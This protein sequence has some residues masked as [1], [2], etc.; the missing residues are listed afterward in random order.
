MQSSDDM[1]LVREYADTGSEAA[2]EAL[3]NR[4]LG[5][6]YSAA[7]RQ[8][9][10]RHLAED[11]AQTVFIVLARKAR[12]LPRQTVLVGWLFNTT[13]LTALTQIR[14]AAKR[15]QREQEVEMEHESPA[16]P[17]LWKQIAP[18]LDAALATLNEQDRRA[19]L[20]R[21]FENQ[22]LA[23]V[24]TALAVGEEAAR[25][26]LSR[27]LDKLHGY[28]VRRGI[29]STTTLLAAALSGHAVQAAPAALAKS[30]TL[31]AVAQ[32]AATST[33]TLALTKGVLKLMALSKTQT[34]AVG[35]VVVG[36]ATLSV[37]QHQ[38]KTRLREE[39]Q[40]LNGQVAALQ[41]DNDRMS[42]LLAQANTGPVVQ[43]DPSGELLRL[44]GEVAALRRQTNELQMLAKAAEARPR[45]A[46]GTAVTPPAE[47]SVAELIV[48]MTERGSPDFAELNEVIR[49]GPEAVPALLATLEHSES[50]LVP[51]ALGAIKDTRA[52]DPLITV[53]AQRQ[54]SPYKEVTVE[55]LEI[56][57]GQKAGSD[58][59]AWKA[60]RQNQRL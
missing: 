23:A 13:R 55:A 39:N 28:F 16:E 25:K 42:N 20:L 22:S 44:R 33:S 24:G 48:A 8:V 30:V 53:L 27:A 1:G 17:P 19:V 4:H 35:C 51:K 46:S 2:F 10:E 26:R 6:V 7:L 34:A 41:S 58:A 59:Q 36:L 31:L 9:R 12:G 49:R 60:W 54:S 3:V 18:M 5:L 47:L 21:Y 52:V 37:T 56:I 15:R 29:S 45:F 11:V 40:G 57:T 38:A 14:S 32:G 43:T 50:W